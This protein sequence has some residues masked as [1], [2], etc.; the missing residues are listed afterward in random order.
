MSAKLEWKKPPLW[1][2]D[3]S[4]RIWILWLN[5]KRETLWWKMSLIDRDWCECVCSLGN[6]CSWEE[7]WRRCLS[8]T[9]IRNADYSFKGRCCCF[10]MFYPI[11]CVVFPLMLISFLW[12]HHQISNITVNMQSPSFCLLHGVKSFSVG[13][14]LEKNTSQYKFLSL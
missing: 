8:Q 10:L 12:N 3:S 6:I 7:T 2:S 1:G 4:C 13:G 11:N 5:V 9:N 14:S